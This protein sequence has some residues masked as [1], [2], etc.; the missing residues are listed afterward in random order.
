MQLNYEHVR[1]NSNNNSILLYYLFEFEMP[2]VHTFSIKPI[3]NFTMKAVMS[4][5]ILRQDS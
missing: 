1:L 4:D 2:T 5:V 3:D